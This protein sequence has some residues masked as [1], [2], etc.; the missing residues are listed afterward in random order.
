[1]T[2]NLV[3]DDAAATRVHYYADTN[4]G[5]SGSPVFNRLWEVIA[6]HH[7]G[8]PYPPE[9]VTRKTE[10]DVLYAFN[11]GIPMKAILAEFKTRLDGKGV[12]L[13]N[14]VPEAK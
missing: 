10:N 13:M 11:E 14:Y 3:A 9:S 2:Q 12:A 7:S 1:M 8:G 5:S 4:H 6:L